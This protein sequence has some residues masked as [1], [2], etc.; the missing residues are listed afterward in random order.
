MKRRDHRPGYPR[1]LA[2]A[3]TLE[4][5]ERFLLRPI[6]PDDAPLLVDFSAHCDPNDLRLRFFLTMRVL[7]PRLAYRLSHLDYVREMAL[8][9]VPLAPDG[10]CPIA[11]VVRLAGDAGGT[12]A[13]Y[14]IEVRS[15]LKRHGLGRRLMQEILSYART[16]GYARVVGEVL[17][18]NAAMLHL[19][20]ELGARVALADS[21]V[22]RVVFELAE[23]Q[24]SP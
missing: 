3:I 1:G 2:H 5:G 23:A 14:A 6:R 20:R 16:H 17:A 10:V 11:G 12:E 13:E 8:I 4:D 15:D 9:A 19:A 22:V 7:P 18:E 24:A 21:G